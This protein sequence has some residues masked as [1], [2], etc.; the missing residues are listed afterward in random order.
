M[1]DEAWIGDD[2]YTDPCLHGPIIDSTMDLATD[3]LQTGYMVDPNLYEGAT[4]HIS[5][6][7]IYTTNW[8]GHAEWINSVATIYMSGGEVTLLRGIGVGQNGY[9]YLYMTGG[10]F[11]ILGTEPKNGMWIPGTSDATDGHVQL[12]AGTMDLTKFMMRKNDNSGGTMDIT[13]GILIIDGD[14]CRPD[15]H[16]PT[17][18]N[19]LEYISNDWLTAYDGTGELI[20]TYDADAN[21]TTVIGKTPP[22]L[23]ATNPIPRSGALDVAPNPTLGWT[24][25]TDASDPNAHEIYLGTSYD[26]VNDAMTSSPEYQGAQNLDF[27][28]FSPDLLELGATY[29]WRVDEVSGATRQ[30]GKVWYFE[31]TAGKARNPHPGHGTWDIPVDVNIGWTPGGAFAAR[32]DVYFGTDLDEVSNAADPNVLPGR[33]QQDVN[34]YDPPGDLEF[35]TRYYVRVDEVGP[36]ITIKGDVWSFMTTVGGTTVLK[37]DVSNSTP[38]N[39]K[40]GWTLITKESFGEQGGAVTVTDVN[41]TGIY[42]TLDVGDS[43]S[44]SGN[45][46]QRGEPLARDYFYADG[47]SGPPDADFIMTL[48]NLDPAWYV[49]TTIHNSLDVDPNLLSSVEVSGKVGAVIPDS[50]VLQSRSLTDDALGYSQVQ[51]WATGA[52]DV[53]VRYVCAE[54]NR[55]QAYFTGFILNAFPPDTR[56]AHYPWPYHLGTEM[57]PDANL[58]WTPGDY[59]FWHDVYFGTNF[60]NVNDA[61]S[62]TGLGVYKGRQ[63]LDANMYDLGLLDLDKSYYWRIDE[64]NDDGVSTWRGDVWNFRVANH[65]VID[66]MESYDDDAIVPENPINATWIDG[67]WN[68]TGSTVWLEYG[69]GAVVHGGAKAMYL[70]YDNDYG[71]GVEKYSEVYAST[72]AGAKN[73]GVTKNW[74][75]LEVK[76]LALFFYGDPNNEMEPMYVVL[77]DTPSN[78]ATTWY[79]DYGEDIND[80]R[81]S[82]WHEWNMALSDFNEGDFDITD[83]N[84]IHIGL[85]DWENPV[86]GGTGSVYLDDIRLYLPKC[87]PWL[88]KPAY[89]FSDN[90]LV[91][92]S[93]VRELAEDWLVV[94]AYATPPDGGKLVLHYEFE[95][96]SGGD[97]GDSSGYGY[98]G[99]AFVDVN[100]TP[101][102][103]NW[104]PGLGKYGGAIK[105]DKSYGISIPNDVFVDHSIS[106]EITISV[107]VNWDDPNTMSDNSSYRMFACRT[108]DTNSGDTD[109]VL[110][111]EASW[112]R[113]RRLTLIDSSES[114]RYSGLEDSDWSGGWNHYAFVKN[115]DK[116]YLRIYHNG[117]LASEGNGGP[118]MEVPSLIY[119]GMGADRPPGDPR[120]LHDQYTGWLDD[121]RFYSYALSHGEV[122]SLAEVSTHFGAGDVDI[123]ADETI[124][125]KDWALFADTWLT[126]VHWPEE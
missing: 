103:A 69:E 102:D 101:G 72:A 71:M 119:I 57:P 124:N 59:A 49:L 105:F 98:D 5:G 31:V 34:S 2:D 6:G 28:S 4:M 90:C 60:D 51:F 1:T 76:I 86:A 19:L 14:P 7:K 55:E 122:L 53:T 123:Y 66:D 36:G 81:E 88:S 112:K 104:L 91:D 42:I 62:S 85:G 48:G 77:E 67:W 89:D 113:N 8:F 125:M 21:E 9:G 65:T 73:L 108:W 30:T 26:G 37:C 38:A 44:M 68:Y 75:I 100:Q 35:S 114:T 46:Y 12:D 107:W 20:V 23:R 93:D 58:S 32:H 126:E 63:S 82:E 110:A 80:I 33:G 47:E 99:F 45:S 27:N 16:E 79:G 111:I 54:T 84:R 115:T 3:R 22:L 78:K 97:I 11:R 87:V 15:L 10:V 18:R 40:A 106:R 43:G 121:F 61:T 50:N 109:R 117:A 120:G 116:D 25:G 83:V 39:L 56:Y 13:E 96:G 17:P 95:E 41:G 70:E 64:V 52:G 92:M 29:Y 24:A 74:T 94:R 118:A